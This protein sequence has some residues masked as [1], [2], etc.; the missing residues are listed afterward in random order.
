MQLQWNGMHMQ[1]QLLAKTFILN[2]QKSNLF[3][4]LKYKLFDSFLFEFEY[5]LY[6]CSL[7]NKICVYVQCAST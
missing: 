1:M 7:S 5:N 3:K 4:C 6:I 2:E